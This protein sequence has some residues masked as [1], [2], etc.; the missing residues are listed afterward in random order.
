MNRLLILSALFL[1]ASNASA[2]SWSG[3]STSTS[4]ELYVSVDSMSRPDNQLTVYANPNTSC[5]LT[6]VMFDFFFK[7]PKAQALGL[8]TRSARVQYRIDQNGLWDGSDSVYE[9]F[10]DD[11]GMTTITYKTVISLDLINE[12][13]WGSKIIFRPHLGSDWGTTVRYPLTGSRESLDTLIDTCNAQAST[14]EWGGSAET[15]DLRE[16]SS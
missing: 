14:L 2:Q 15:V 16:W 7:N 3:I 11:E 5:S 6:M 13:M 8:S 12:M 4:G 1:L 10:N 9:V